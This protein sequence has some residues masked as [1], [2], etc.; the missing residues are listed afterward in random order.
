MHAHGTK[1]I[2]MSIELLQY[3]Y[4][5]NQPVNQ[6]Q[7]CMMQCAYK[8]GI[9]PGNKCPKWPYRR[10]VTCNMERSTKRVLLYVYCT[11]GTYDPTNGIKH[12]VS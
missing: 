10:P 8:L 6:A 12:V 11:R 9:A 2:Q 7:R 1:H 3:G 4:M 5:Q